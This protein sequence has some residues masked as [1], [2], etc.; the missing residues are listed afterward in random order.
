MIAHQEGGVEFCI[1][2]EWQH[3]TN[4]GLL[5][6]RDPESRLE[7]FFLTSGIQVPG[8]VSDALLAEIARVIAH[9]E[10]ASVSPQGEHNELI[11]YD[12]QGFGLYQSEIVDWELRFVAGARK[13]L[14]I[15]ALGDVEDNRHT[16]DQIYQTIQLSKLDPVEDPES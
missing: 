16:I 14:M 10:V 15:I 11:H 7:L 9:P 13:S 8:Q 4:D 1:P 2:Q 6:V 5:I 3:E 12:V